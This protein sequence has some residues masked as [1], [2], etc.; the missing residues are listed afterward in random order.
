MGFL[1]TLQAVPRFT[2]IVF[3]LVGCVILL[4]MRVEGT[5]APYGV[6]LVVWHTMLHVCVAESVLNGE[7][8]NSAQRPQPLKQ[9]ALRFAGS[10]RFQAVQ[11]ANRLV[12]RVIYLRLVYCDSRR[13]SEVRVCPGQTMSLDH[14]TAE[15][16]TSVAL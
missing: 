5:D 7:N 1:A 12:R 4:R 14:R 8:D 3:P 10:K 2:W 13:L 15:D 11:A 6:P 9:Q 16:V